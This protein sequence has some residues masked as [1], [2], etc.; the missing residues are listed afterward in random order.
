M[1]HKCAH[2]FNTK[3]RPPEGKKKKKEA[4]RKKKKHTGKGKRYTLKLSF[5]LKI[6]ICVLRGKHL[7]KSG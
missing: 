4:L 1:Y 7:Q 2:V 3:M 6:C 5:I